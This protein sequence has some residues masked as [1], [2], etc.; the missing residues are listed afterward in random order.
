MKIK[1]YEASSMEEAVAK[2]K[3][4][5]G[6]EAIILYTRRLQRQWP[7]SLFN[8]SGVEIT[9]ALDVNPVD[10]RENGIRGKGLPH[11][12]ME[13]YSEKLDL[14]QLEIEEIKSIVKTIADELADP[15]FQGM[16]TCFLD[17]YERLLQSKVANDRAKRLIRSARDRLSPSELADPDVLRKT[18]IDELVKLLPVSAPLSLD[19]GRQRII[20]LI[21]PTGAGKTTTIAKLAARYC[22]YEGKKGVFLTADTYRIAAVD[23]LRTYADIIGVPT[24]IIFSNQDAREALEKH[25]D[26]DLVFID[27]AGRS[28]HNE[29]QINELVGLMNA[30][31]PD[32]IHL[33]LSMTTKMTDQMNAIKRFSVVPVNRLIFTKLDETNT[34]GTML[35]IVDKV[36]VPISYLT[37][38]QNVP[39]D[40][41]VAE[42]REL[43]CAI[44][45][46]PFDG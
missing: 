7:F 12:S 28:P 23:Q 22:L 40:I 18:L 39:E 34:P 19:D 10:Q 33:V 26:K 4:D 46:V 41:K 25:Q 32:E 35:N 45:G 9:A 43:A 16:P 5:L 42:S 30:C 15:L 20:A 24:E 14:L 21:G 27:T 36:E 13:L 3:L 2:V 38:G 44:L 6:P 11:D 1:R 29:M 8:K 37:I 31:S 17:T